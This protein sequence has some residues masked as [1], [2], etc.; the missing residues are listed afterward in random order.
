MAR[1]VACSGATASPL[2]PLST[3]PAKS[4][5]PLEAERRPPHPRSCPL[6]NASPK[7]FPPSEYAVIR[8]SALMNRPHISLNFAISADGKISSS[9]GKA[10][11]WTSEADSQRLKLL[12]ESADALLVGRGTLVA[13]RMTLTAPQNPLRCVI[14]RGGE[15]DPAH[16]LFQTP[17]GT[18]HLLGSEQP[19]TPIPGSSAHRGTLPAFI[20][21]LYRDL[22]VERLHCEGGGQL[23]HELA[24]LD[25]IDEIHLTWAGHTLFGGRSAPGITGSPGAFLPESRHFELSH[26]EPRQEIGECFLSYRRVAG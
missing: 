23:V 12:R 19:P 3:S 2:A 10:S 20:T 6:A 17:G 7:L 21:T 11:G 8:D 14:S 25:L 15:F 18:I 4:N 13:D 5:E 1:K 24:A 16:P 26:F 9:S 22:G